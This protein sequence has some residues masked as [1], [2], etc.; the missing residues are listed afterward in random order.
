MGSLGSQIT[1]RESNE[2]ILEVLNFIEI[3]KIPFIVYLIY[4][5]DASETTK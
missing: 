3:R 4:S 1:K 5:N 2:I